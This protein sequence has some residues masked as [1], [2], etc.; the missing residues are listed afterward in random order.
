MGHEMVG[1]GLCGSLGFVMVGIPVHGRSMVTVVGVGR[2]AETRWLSGKARPWMAKCCC[3]S[4]TMMQESA[5][6]CGQ[7]GPI[8][9][10]RIPWHAMVRWKSMLETCWKSRTSCK[11][12]WKV[13]N[14]DKRLLP[15][16]RSQMKKN[17]KTQMNPIPCVV[18]VLHAYRLSWLV[19]CCFL[20]HFPAYTLHF[21]PLPLQPNQSLPHNPNSHFSLRLLCN[22]VL[23]I[24]ISRIPYPLSISCGIPH[25]SLVF[26]V[27]YSG[28][29]AIILHIICCVS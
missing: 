6:E 20:A 16:T 21:P 8:A 12:V 29:D 15:C 25:I 2:G 14:Q 11:R 23:Y 4:W 24:P 13:W 7:V 1:C 22:S 9:C 28:P 27:L 19:W 10:H 5:S 26:C 18:G 3:G 17:K